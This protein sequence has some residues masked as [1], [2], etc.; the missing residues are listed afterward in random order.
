MRNGTRSARWALVLL[1]ALAAGC[2]GKKAPSPEQTRAFVPAIEEYLQA[3]SMGMKIVAFESI[4][5]QAGTA[6]AVVRMAAKDVGG[7]LPIASRGQ[8]VYQLQFGS[9]GYGL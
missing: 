9:Q 2:G 4:E 8:V 5:I 3:K 6:T 7:L 1:A